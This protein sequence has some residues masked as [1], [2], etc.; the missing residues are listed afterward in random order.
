MDDTKEHKHL[1]DT[2]MSA[3]QDTSAFSKNQFNHVN[4]LQGDLKKCKDKN[5]MLH[6]QNI[7]LGIENK[8]LHDHINLLTNALHVRKNR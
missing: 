7:Q 8:L 5:A 4:M 6:E 3:L 1:F 2:C